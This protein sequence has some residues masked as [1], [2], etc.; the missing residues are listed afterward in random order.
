MLLTWCNP[1]LSWLA[2]QSIPAWAQS[3]Q[4]ELA[5]GTAGRGPC[6]TWVP[7]LGGEA[8]MHKSPPR[9]CADKGEG[10][11]S[12]MRPFFP[13]LSPE[14]FI[15]RFQ[16]GW[17]RSVGGII[18]VGFANGEAEVAEVEAALRFPG[19]THLC[20]NCP[21][22]LCMQAAVCVVPSAGCLSLPDPFGKPW[23]SY[24]ISEQIWGLEGNRARR[25]TSS[26]SSPRDGTGRSARC[27]V[28]CWR[29]PFPK[30]DEL[31]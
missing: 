28:R 27:S 7:W 31:V 18:S 4:D 21:G 22:C 23:C 11:P 9:G 8:G 17:K 26:S 19:C 6:A 24:L 15:R 30:L 3:R 14:P 1:L 5:N 25:G 2:S 10:W 16:K 13:V 20:Q 29:P 12:R